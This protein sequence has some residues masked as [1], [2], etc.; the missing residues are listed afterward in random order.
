MIT[1]Q[2]SDTKKPFSVNRNTPQAHLA[3][4]ARRWLARYRLAQLSLQ[5]EDTQF[6]LVFPDGQRRTLY[7]MSPP[8][9]IA[10]R[11]E[12]SGRW[13]RHQRDDLFDGPPPHSDDFYQRYLARNHLPPW[14][15]RGGHLAL[16]ED[17]DEARLLGV[18]VPAA[19]R[20]VEATVP[21]EGHRLQHRSMLRS[22]HV[23]GGGIV[24]PTQIPAGVGHWEWLG[25]T[26][27]DV[28]EASGFG[29]SFED[30][31]SARGAGAL[32]LNPERQDVPSVVWYPDAQYFNPP[33]QPAEPGHWA[34]MTTRDR[35]SDEMMAALQLGGTSGMS[36]YPTA[37]QIFRLRQQYRTQRGR[38]DLTADI[39][40]VWIPGDDEPSDS[41]GEGPVL[42]PLSPDDIEPG[43]FV[44]GDTP[45]ASPHFTPSSDGD[46]EEAAA[47]H[48]AHG[49]LG[50]GI[51]PSDF[52]PTNGS[53]GGKTDQTATLSRPRYFTYRIGQTPT[54]PGRVI[55]LD[56]ARPRLDVPE[57]HKTYVYTTKG[58]QQHPRH[59]ELDWS[60]KKVVASLAR[61]RDQINRRHGWPNLR[62]GTREVYAQDE[63]AWLEAKVHEYLDAGCPYDIVE[64][65]RGFLERFCDRGER[66]E[67]GIASIMLRIKRV[68][69]K[70]RGSGDGAVDEELEEEEE[71]S[72][73]V[74]QDQDH[75]DED[76]DGEEDAG[77]RDEPGGEHSDSDDSDWNP[78]LVG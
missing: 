49:V 32:S 72:G 22:V 12:A 5:P 42:Q 9:M 34:F 74:E 43:L 40:L 67:A 71:V 66:T 10:V 76:E 46:Q 35:D 73:S 59:A 6:A 31:T 75:V 65:C 58:W 26:D 78:I 50:P 41:D 11:D 39:R 62:S 63:K 57:E 2:S 48:Q 69:R 36:N 44:T 77:S 24:N 45:E 3:H 64:T 25:S 20:V 68:W 52:D 54:T 29:S 53:P 7:L 60:S 51:H 37:S 4:Y 30:V 1:R 28:A 17:T 21:T 13:S 16:L 55:T 18:E 61:W 19:P 15:L 23:A 70:G 14:F 56:R 27:R 33:Q 8:R 38:E 47:I